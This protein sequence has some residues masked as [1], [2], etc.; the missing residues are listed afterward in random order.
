MSDPLS[1][2]LKETHSSFARKFFVYI[3]AFALLELLSYVLPAC[4]MVKQIS[5]VFAIVS[6]PDW[7]GI[8]AITL[9]DLPIV[10]HSSL[11]METH[12]YMH[13][14]VWARPVIWRLNKAM[15]RK[16]AHPRAAQWFCRFPSYEACN[17]HIVRRNI[18]IYATSTIKLQQFTRAAKQLLKCTH[19]Y[20]DIH[21]QSVI[22]MC[23]NKYRQVIAKATITNRLWEKNTNN[24]CLNSFCTGYVTTTTKTTQ[25]E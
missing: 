10:A 9:I 13:T 20:V 12:L 6:T 1:L 5:F 14:C 22:R 21:I 7:Q 8:G 4:V 17:A 2:P 15:Q 16:S 11:K 23:V 3:L 19:M 25:W 18:W 24:C